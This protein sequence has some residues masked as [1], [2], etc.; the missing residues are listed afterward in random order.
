MKAST[1]D[2]ASTGVFTGLRGSVVSALASKPGL[3]AKEVFQRLNDGD[4]KR[5]SYPAVHK[6]LGVLS[7]EGVIERSGSGY[8]LSASWVAALKR[9]AKSVPLGAGKRSLLE[10]GVGSS[11]NPDPVLAGREAAAAAFGQCTLQKTPQLCLLFCSP[12]YCAPSGRVQAG[13]LSVIGNCPLAGCSSS[14]EFNG[15]VSHGTVL[16]IVYCA[17]SSDFAA[18]VASFDLSQVK[19]KAQIG[20]AARE[21]A[22]GKT[23]PTLGLLLL[24]SMVK[25]DGFANLP[26]DLVS[27]LSSRAGYPVVGGQ[28]GDEWHFEASYQFANSKQFLYSAVLVNISCKTGVELT[29]LHGYLPLGGPLDLT[30][31]P[32]GEL[33][34]VKIRGRAPLD[35][36]HAY[37]KLMRVP[38][39]AVKELLPAFIYEV[40]CQNKFM[41]LSSPPDYSLLRYPLK[42]NRDG[43]ILFSMPFEPAGKPAYVLQTS[44]LQLQKAFLDAVNAPETRNREEPAFVLVFCCALVEAVTSRAGASLEVKRPKVAGPCVM[45]EVSPGT[46]GKAK[47]CNGSVVAV[48]F[49][50]N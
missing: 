1:T 4:G 33:S 8:G 23:R 36:V 44:P 2:F 38:V 27:A 18:S 12:K 25:L 20:V 39:A 34:T 16:A 19:T 49:A 46:K 11:A 50:K 45:G 28:A 40:V 29:S 21:L 10:V 48:A 35:A 41:P 31:K 37:S 32:G 14:G 43:T 26:R 3:T 9:F 47:Y 42:A 7:S 15:K 22:A 24:P 13:V 30:L 6:C 17:N 5:Y